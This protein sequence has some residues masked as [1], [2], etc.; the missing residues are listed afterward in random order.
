MVTCLQTTKNALVTKQ[1]GLF[2]VNIPLPTKN[3]QVLGIVRVRRS[4]EVGLR[5]PKRPKASGGSKEEGCQSR[6]NGRCRGIM[7][8]AYHSS[9]Q[10][11]TVGRPENSL[12]EMQGK[13]GVPRIPDYGLKGFYGD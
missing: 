2:Q 4:A 13:H 12:P 6:N 5:Q 9:S 3:Q 8:C 7:T 11:T 1:F 10:Y